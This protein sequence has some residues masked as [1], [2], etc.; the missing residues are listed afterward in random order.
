MKM[1]AMP[2]DQA[3]ASSRTSSAFSRWLKPVI[4]LG[5]SAFFLWL[6]LRRLSVDETWQAITGTTWS[7]IPWAVL[8]LGVGYGA[9]IVR[10][11]MMLR[12]AAP[13]LRIKE[14]G[15]PFLVSIAANN[16]LPLRMGDVLRLFAFSGRQGLEAGRI[17]GTLVVE[18]LL[19]LFALLAIFAIALPLAATGEISR[20]MTRLASWAAVAGAVAVSGVFLLPLIERLV[21]SRI[22]H[23]DA[24][25]RSSLARRA[26]GIVSMLVDTIVRL[27]R[28]FTVLA[29]IALSAVVWAFEGGVFIIAAKATSVPLGTGPAFFALAVAT[30]STLLPSSPGYIGTF[31]FFAIQSAI[32]FGAAEA[33]AAAFAVLA[34][35]LL[36]VPTTFAGLVVFVAGSFKSGQR[37]LG[38]I[39]PSPARSDQ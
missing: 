12:P 1:V 8:S 36:W 2:S 14:V 18:R 9:R 38:V 22:R 26:F 5:V 28:P 25:Q 37:Q 39:A 20:T 11:W 4:G 19:D 6:A 10:W 23:L 27:G 33:N 32:A 24:V 29:L 16:V 21:L 3:S 13:E 15:G 17:G 34:H 30:L 7:L 35:L 31:H